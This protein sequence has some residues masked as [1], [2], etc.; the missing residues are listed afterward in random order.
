MPKLRRYSVFF[1]H[2]WDY[3]AELIT[4]KKWLS[5]ANLINIADFSITKFKPLDTKSNRE[6]EIELEK[7]IKMVHI[8]VVIAG[9]YT[10][11]RKWMQKEIDIAKANNIPIIGIKP[12]GAQKLPISVKN[13]AKELVSWNSNSLISAIRKWARK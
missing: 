1:S 7:I 9:I 4:I 6:L 11:H 5:E 3:D 8:V 2:S 12:R 13:N 10:S